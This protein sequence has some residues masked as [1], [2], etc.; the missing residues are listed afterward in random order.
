MIKLSSSQYESIARQAFEEELEKLGMRVPFS[1]GMNVPL[2]HWFNNAYNP[3]D[4]M[5]FAPGI[6]QLRKGLADSIKNKRAGT[7]SNVKTKAIAGTAK[8]MR[9]L[10]LADA[11]AMVASIPVPFGTA[12]YTTARG[13]MQAIA[14]KR[15]TLNATLPVGTEKA[16]R[17]MDLIRRDPFDSLLKELRRLKLG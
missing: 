5:K 7:I 15:G 6:K 13:T 10:T 14:K 16:T 8:Q 9:N 17:N 11:P 2:K 1:G 3:L 12:G 4:A